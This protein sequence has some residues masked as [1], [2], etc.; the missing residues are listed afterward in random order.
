MRTNYFCKTAGTEVIINSSLII[1]AIIKKEEEEERKKDACMHLIKKA[2]STLKTI[3][4][5]LCHTTHR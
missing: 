2:K 3:S 5:H 1:S 4:H